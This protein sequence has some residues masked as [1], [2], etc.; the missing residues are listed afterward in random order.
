QEM[1]AALL[2]H[3][4]DAIQ[5]EGQY[6]DPDLLATPHPG[7]IDASMVA[8]MEKM[9]AGVRDA[10]NDKQNLRY[11]LGC[12]LTEPKSHVFF[13]APE[14]GLGPAAF[15]R[16]LKR[17]G[18]RLDLKS[19]LL[20]LGEQFFLNGNALTTTDADHSALRQLADARELP[21]GKNIDWSRTLCELL[22]RAYCDGFVHTE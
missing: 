1:S 15:S 9:L 18:A 16:L 13:D 19:R 12:Y 10:V 6:R 22:H 3:V 7:E 8:R 17:D 5:F 11:F 2:D 4:R 20:Y 14:S 21:G